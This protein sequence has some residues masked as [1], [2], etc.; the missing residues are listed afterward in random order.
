MSIDIVKK[1]GKANM[2]D[3]SKRTPTYLVLHYTASTRSNTGQAKAIADMF[4]SSNTKAS[5]DFIC[6]DNDIVQYNPDPTKKYCWAVGGSKY[7]VL[8]NS[9]AAKFYGKAKNQNCISI[10]IVSSKKNSKSLNANDKDWYFSD[11]ALNNALKLTV[12]L[13]KLY[14]I[15]AN[16]V[17][18]HNMVTG[19]LCPSNWSIDEKALD[20]YK[21]FIKDVK[22]SLNKSSSSTS[23]TTSKS[24][25]SSTSKTTYPGVFPTDTIKRNSNSK[26]VKYLQQFLNWYGYP[27]KCDGICGSNTVNAITEFQKA[28]KLTANGI[29]NNTCLKKAKS[30]KK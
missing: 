20:N 17:I 28:N 12:Y 24:T 1:C 3:C 23:N 4:A 10:E 26:Q 8:T 2:T 9:L 29:W 11:K 18:T 22:K 16:H 30:C 13:M 14:N 5:A 7:S 27:L 21:N 19:K 6:D 25:T 15:D